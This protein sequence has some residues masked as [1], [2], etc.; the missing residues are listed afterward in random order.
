MTAL[1]MANEIRRLRAQLK[2]DLKAGKASIVALL[3][4]PPAYL[5]T[6]FTGFSPSQEAVSSRPSRSFVCP[7]LMRQPRSSS[8]AKHYGTWT[9]QAPVTGDLSGC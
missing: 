1:S 4:D 3:L 5:Q 2:R 8:R 9:E 7:R 6:V